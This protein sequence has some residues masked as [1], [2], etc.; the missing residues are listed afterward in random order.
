MS[1]RLWEAWVDQALPLAFCLESSCSGFLLSIFHP[2]GSTLSCVSASAELLQLD[3]WLDHQDH[4]NFIFASMGMGHSCSPGAGAA[5]CLFP[6]ISKPHNP[7]SWYPVSKT[8]GGRVGR[9]TLDPP[10]G[11]LNTPR[12]QSPCSSLSI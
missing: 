6:S 3:S 2:F 7:A 9:H 10:E 4:F 11:S 12:M 1:L 5:S 8:R